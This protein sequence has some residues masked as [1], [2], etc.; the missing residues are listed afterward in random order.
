ME[1]L[2]TGCTFVRRILACVWTVIDTFLAHRYVGGSFEGKLIEVDKVKFLAFSFQGE[3]LEPGEGILTKLR[4]SQSSNIVCMEKI[5]IV[6][7]NIK[8]SRNQNNENY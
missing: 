2:G 1:K 6:D 3:V 7:K 8:K 5:I 4:Y